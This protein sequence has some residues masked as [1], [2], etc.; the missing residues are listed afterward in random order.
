MV[1]AAKIEYQ[2]GSEGEQTLQLLLNTIWTYMR[3]AS[4]EGRCR[5]YRL[6]GYSDLC[7]RRKD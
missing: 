2:L 4:R 5:S 6:M 1:E 3:R 7:C